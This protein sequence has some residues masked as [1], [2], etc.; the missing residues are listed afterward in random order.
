MKYSV[1]LHLST[2]SLLSLLHRTYTPSVHHAPTDY[3][4]D[5]PGHDVR[6]HTEKAYGNSVNGTE[7]LEG[8]F[9]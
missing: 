9:P 1:A 7:L 4:G 6:L 3:G 5:T 2:H 8:K